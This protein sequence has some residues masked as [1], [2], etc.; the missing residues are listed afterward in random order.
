MEA[1]VLLLHGSRTVVAAQLAI[2]AS[3]SDE[4]SKLCMPQGDAQQFAQLAVSNT[5]EKAKQSA[6]ASCLLLHLGLS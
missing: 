2:N 6:R 3:A 5:L 4:E 1:G